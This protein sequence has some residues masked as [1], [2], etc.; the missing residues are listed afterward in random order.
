MNVVK[1]AWRNVWRNKRRSGVT[2]AAMTLALLV[3]VLYSGLVVGYMDGMERDLLDLEIGDVQIHAN[4]YLERPSIY[5]AIESPNALITQIEAQGFMAAPR[6][7]AGALAAGEESSAGVAL[8]G[9]VVE[10][11]A[12]VSSIGTAVA[13]GEWLDPNDPQGVVLGRRLARTLAVKPGDELVLLTQAYDGSMAHDLFSVRGILKGIAD[14]TDRSAVLM[15]EGSFRQLM[16]FPEA[17][18]Q[19]IVRRPEGS[20]LDATAAVLRGIAPELDVK[21]WKELMPLVA[22][23]FESTRG[24]IV[25]IFLVVYLAIA[26]LV[27]NA[28]LMAVFERVREFGILKAIGFGPFRVFGLI[29][30][31]AGIQTAVALVVGLL[32][33]LPGMWYLS[34]YGIDVGTLGG[35]SVMGLAMPPVWNGIYTLDTIAVPI[36][37]LILI[38]LIAVL[39]PALKAALIEPV[40]AMHHQ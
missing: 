8:R 21:T 29:V 19:I 40:K 25:V 1:I 27:L 3:E 16:E 37:L 4:D 23:M 7:L 26:I 11:E 39:Y 36:F 18:H 6:Q 12:K 35:L 33:A 34:S 32:L 17:A 20:E 30:I 24:M 15:T 38:V 10:L 14:G 28:M 13:E 22:S 9:I 5:S 31:E 2:I